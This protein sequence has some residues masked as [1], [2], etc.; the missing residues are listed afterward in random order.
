MNS[1]SYWLPSQPPGSG[2]ADTLTP[3]G[4][5]RHAHR[6][7]QVS[8]SKAEILT[9]RADVGRIARLGEDL[10]VLPAAEAGH[11]G[12]R[13]VGVVRMGD[14]ADD[15]GLVHPLRRSRQMLADLQAGKGGGD[16][17]KLAANLRRRVRLHI[18]HVLMA[19]A[20][21]EIEK[22]NRFGGPP[23]PRA[24]RLSRRRLQHARQRQ[25][26][27][28]GQAP[29][30][31]RLTPSNAVA[32]LRG[33]SVNAQHGKDLDD[34]GIVT[35]ANVAGSMAGE[36]L[37]HERAA[38]GIAGPNQSVRMAYSHTDVARTPDERVG[39]SL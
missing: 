5:A 31:H 7:R 15:G 23:R 14:A 27:E 10:C 34:G 35:R 26:A 36:P 11:H 37:D 3:A 28:Q 12:Q 33:V 1:G 18:E 16:G 25:T 9:H 19:W 4:I 20:T 32:Q 6:A 21:E 39:S 22:D 8:R 24:R 13:V 2:T 29:D 17:P 30:A 38:K